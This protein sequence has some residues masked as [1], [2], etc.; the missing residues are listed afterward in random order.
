[1]AGRGSAL[2]RAIKFVEEGDIRE[3]RVA[4]QI[5]QEVFETRV[6]LTQTEMDKP[7]PIRQRKPKTNSPAD[8]VDVSK[9]NESLASA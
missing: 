2:S 8:A 5:M 3:V 6:R 1:M 9:A 7:K 4:L